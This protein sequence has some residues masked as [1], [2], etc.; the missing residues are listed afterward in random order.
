MPLHQLQSCPAQNNKLPS[1][2]WDWGKVSARSSCCSGVVNLPPAAEPT[3]CPS[4]LVPSP[5]L[6]SCPT[7]HSCTEIRRGCNM[8]T[9]FA[10]HFR[11]VSKAYWWEQ[12]N[13]HLKAVFSVLP[14]YRP[15]SS[16]SLHYLC[17]VCC[18]ST[19]P[20][21]LQCACIWFWTRDESR[22]HL[23]YSQGNVSTDEAVQG[24]GWRWAQNEP[25]MTMRHE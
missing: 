6:N 14:F 12:Y 9:I 4:Y 3:L 13:P 1:R 16:V 15:P 11:Q 20:P 25:F 21:E 19:S 23:K 5:T 10:S 7:K 24:E 22:H 17:A 2:S 18:I 8:T